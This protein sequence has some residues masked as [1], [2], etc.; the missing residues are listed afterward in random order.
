MSFSHEMNSVSDLVIE[1][2]K[3]A[4]CNG[5]GISFLKFIQLLLEVLDD[6]NTVI[7]GN[8]MFEALHLL[9]FFC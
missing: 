8:L 5:V 2:W 6:L 4:L 3:S 1:S 9:I 7:V